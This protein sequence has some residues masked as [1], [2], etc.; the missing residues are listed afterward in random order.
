MRQ[1]A[2]FCRAQEAI[3][4]AAMSETN[5]NDSGSSGLGGKADSGRMPLGLFLRLA[6]MMMLQYAIWGAWLPLLYFY[7]LDGRGFG[8]TQIAWIF[9]VGAVGAVVA[10]FIAGQSVDRYISTEKYL[11]VCHLL[12]AIVVWQLAWLENYYGFLVFSL[13]YSL[14]Y[15]PTIPLTNSLSFHH[16]PEPDKNF[17]YVRVCGG[18]GWILA[19]IGVAQWLAYA[20]SPSDAEIVDKLISQE[21]VAAEQRDELLNFRRIITPD[22][23]EREGQLLSEE[24]TSVMLD[25]GGD[26]PQFV[27]KSDARV[28]KAKE[29][30]DGRSVAL[31]EGMGDAFRLS[32]I[33]GAILG[34]YCFTLPHTPPQ[35]GE[36]EAAYSQAWRRIKRNPLLTLFVV[37]LVISCVHQFYFVHT[38]RFLGTYS[39]RSEWIDKIFGVGGGGLMTLGQMSEIV[40]MV[41]FPIYGRWFSRKFLLMVGIV[42]YIVRFAAFAYAAQ[43]ETNYGIPAS[44]SIVVGL[45]MH[46]PCF[47]LFMF[48]GFIVVDE[49]TTSDVRG[50]AQSMYNLVLVG[51]G[52]IV[53]SFIAGKIADWCTTDAG[54]DYTRLFSWPLWGSVGCLAAMLVFYPWGR[55]KPAEV[56]V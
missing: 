25:T 41:T 1:L 32:A 31:A 29:V 3:R 13:V 16:L 43:I 55:R 51:F 4:I 10:P 36:Q 40:V 12:G 26:Q 6:F 33:L 19:G 54:M 14:I 46:G 34:L 15:M 56:T 24:E 47:T 21:K 44:I 45:L 5:E 27:S 28:Y 2:S 22:G 49:E 7:L 37:S 30:E 48:L 23:S 38:A 9:A 18:P 42:A 17:G 53:G 20:Y 11:A 39:L 8:N 35:K 52:I 50:T